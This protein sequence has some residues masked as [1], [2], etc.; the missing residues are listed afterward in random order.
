MESGQQG[1]EE[2]IKLLGAP[3]DY[4]RESNPPKV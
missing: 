1:I 4:S 3:R 2:F